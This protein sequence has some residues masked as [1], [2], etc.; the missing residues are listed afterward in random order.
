MDT[1]QLLAECDA[2]LRGSDENA[3]GFTS[4]EWSR[5]WNTGEKKTRRLIRAALDTGRMI[6]GWRTEENLIGQRV[7]VP[8]YAVKG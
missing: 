8:V 2:L 1:S 5:E 6:R 7:R 4:A 3:D